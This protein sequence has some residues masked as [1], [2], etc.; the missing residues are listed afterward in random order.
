MQQWLKLTRRLVK[1]TAG[2]AEAGYVAVVKLWKG[3]FNATLFE[4]FL[5][6]HLPLCLHHN[7]NIS[8]QMFSTKFQTFDKLIFIPPPPPKVSLKY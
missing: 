3:S 6:I 2:D 5:L 8:S 1:W 7:A 4:A